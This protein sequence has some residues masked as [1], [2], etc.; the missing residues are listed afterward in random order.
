M[1]KE[2]LRKTLRQRRN[3]LSAKDE[4][5]HLITE[6]ILSF[7]PFQKASVVMLYRS[8]KGEVDTEEL[9]KKCR[10]LGKTCVFPKCVSK[11]EMIAV[12][13]E[14]EGD[15]SVCEFGILEPVSNQVFSK[16]KIDVIIVPAI[17]YDQKNFRM[18]YGGGYYDRYLEHFFGIT[19]GLCYEELLEETVCPGE[20][21]VPVN[22]VVTE[23]G[24][25][26]T[27]EESV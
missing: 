5:S 10:E 24:V 1:T 23:H 26:P 19:V 17:G 7:P 8:A 12:V 22:F 6:H 9:W 14:G 21:D 20:W 3:N 18:G 15:F 16:E 2:E 11:T 4:K 25:R 13:A 27:S